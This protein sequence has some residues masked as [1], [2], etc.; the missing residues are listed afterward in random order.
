MNKRGRSGHSAQNRSRTCHWKSAVSSDALSLIPSGLNYSVFL[1][2]VHPSY[3]EWSQNNVFTGSWCLGTDWELSVTTSWPNNTL[4]QAVSAY[5]TPVMWS[6][7]S[8]SI[9]F[10]WSAPRFTHF[11]LTLNWDGIPSTVN[12]D[13]WRLEDEICPLSCTIIPQVFENRYRISP[14]LC[15]SRQ[16]L[17]SSFPHSSWDTCFDLLSLNMLQRKSFPALFTMFPKH[18]QWHLM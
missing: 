12:T 11:L 14:R 18:L 8:G 9:L 6:I 17:H 7:A 5:R 10:C 13:S 16:N 2:N 1:F 3:W 4:G 15:F